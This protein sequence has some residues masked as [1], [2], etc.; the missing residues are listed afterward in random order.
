METIG[1]NLLWLDPG[2]VGGSEE[3]TLSLLRAV[4]DIDP[5]D[6][7]LR[8]FA[9]RSL[10]AH[11]PD[12]GQRFEVVTAPPMPAGKIGRIVAEHTWLAQR[13]GTVGLVHHAGGVIPAG[14]KNE[15]VLTIL[16]LQPLDMPENFGMT[17]RR[18]L[19]RMIPQSV[20]RARL[21]VVP[22]AFTASRLNGLL[23]V[24]DQKIR[25]VP[26]GIEPAVRIDNDIEH[27]R[28]A[29]SPM[30]LYPAIAYPHKRHLDLIDAFAQVYRQHPDSE[31]VLTGGPGPLTAEITTRIEKLGLGPAVTM[32][33]RIPRRALLSLY[34][35]ATAVVVPSEYEGF[36]L[37]AL[38]AMNLGI[39]VIA[40]DAGSLPEVVGSA[41]LI[42]PPRDPDALAKAMASVLD[43]GTSDELSDLGRRRALLFNWQGSGEA[44]ISAYRDAVE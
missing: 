25:I 38:E 43:P 4:H 16:D 2:V 15:S 39:P 5:L 18:W 40:A 44:L 33:G 23:D 35:R 17:K 10:L 19:G 20:E 11:H 36:G 13:A 24:P 31:L 27:P 22:S 34:G 32:P 26:F 30:F 1:V 21:I 29:G 41:G 9:R 3:Y 42:V 12:I 28:P 14:T 37:P 6:L 8:L 7:E